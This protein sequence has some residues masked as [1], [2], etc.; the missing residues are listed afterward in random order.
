MHP[1]TLSLGSHLSP[2]ALRR[3]LIAGIA[4]GTIVA[5]LIVVPEVMRCGVLCVTDAAVTLAISVAAG[6]L[7]LG[8]LAAFGHLLRRH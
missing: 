6:M 1:A 8:P 3:A 2:N 7:T 4:W 5:A